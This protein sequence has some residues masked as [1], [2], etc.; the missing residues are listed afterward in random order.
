MLQA[1]SASFIA[2]SFS[3]ED[4]LGAQASD[5][6]RR[7]AEDFVH[8]LVGVLADARRGATNAVRRVGEAPRNAGM[9]ANADLRMRQAR[10]EAALDELRVLGEIAVRHRGK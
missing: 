9:R 10:E 8:P 5:L 2:T 1:N 7:H 3:V 4:L 6:L